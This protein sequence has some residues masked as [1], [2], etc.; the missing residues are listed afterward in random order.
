MSFSSP[1]KSLSIVGKHTGR[2]FFVNSTVLRSF[3]NAIS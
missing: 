1:A 2:M 3:N